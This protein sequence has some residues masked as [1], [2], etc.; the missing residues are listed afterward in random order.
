MYAAA[1]ASGHPQP[2]KMADTMLRSREQALA[3]MEARHRI[4]T[5]AAPPK[6][7]ETVTAPKASARKVPEVLKCR[8]RTLAGKQCGFKATYGEFCGKH[9]IQK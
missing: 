2:E 9:A 4:Q 3:L 7:T 1:I 8:S 5:T 6:P